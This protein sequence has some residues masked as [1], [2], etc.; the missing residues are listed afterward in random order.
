MRIR[1]AFIAAQG[2]TPWL[3]TV[4]HIA[5]GISG[6]GYE[7]GKM[8]AQTW[9]AA[10]RRDVRS[11]VCPR[12]G[13][14]HDLTACPRRKAAGHGSTSGSA[15]A[16]KEFSTYETAIGPSSTWRRGNQRPN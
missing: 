7:G 10:L 5:F 1:P 4:G 3:R 14:I 2:R 13:C 6:H 12:G 11:N 15:A 8:R 16:P 9:L